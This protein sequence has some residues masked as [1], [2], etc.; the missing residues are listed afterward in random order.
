MTHARARQRRSLSSPGTRAVRLSP[1][2]LASLVVLGA[3]AGMAYAQDAQDPSQTVVVTGIRR[4]IETSVAIK[5]EST[6]VVEAVSAEDLGKLPDISIA[7]S[8]A[9]L[10]GLTAQRVN[11][12]DQV[13]SVRGMAP[14]FGVTLLNGR[15]VVSTGDNRSVEFD[16]FPSELINGA[17]VY[18][19]PDASLASQGLAGTVNMST[20]R[21]LD[22]RERIIS[23]G[24]RGER[25]SNGA[26]VPG[27]SATGNR[28]SVSYVDQFADNT[29]GL[30]LGFAHLDSTSQERYFKHWWWGNS[31]IWGG[32][33]RGL[34]NTDPAKAP[35][36]LQGFETGVTATKQVRDGALAVLEFK[37]NKDIRSQVDLYYSKFSQDA[38]GRELQADLG[39]NWSGDGTPGHEAN[40]G[41]IYS[42]IK[43]QLIGN[44][45][46]LVGGRV[47]NVDPRI[48]TRYGQRDDTITALGWNTEANLGNGLKGV[49]D[50]SWSKAKRDELVGEA[51]A[52]A[53][54]LGGFDF[55]AN[56]NG[57]FSQFTPLTNYGDPNNIQLRGLSGWG[58]LNG[59]GQAGSLSPINVNDELK[60][61]RLGVKKDLDWGAVN[62]FEGGVNYSQRSKDRN[63]TQTIYALKNG[64]TC[65][66]SDVCQPFP[67]GLLQSPVNLGFSN[68]P[69]LVSFDMMAAINAGLYNSGLVNQSSAPG[70]IWGVDE[71]VTTAYGKLDLD[72]N[73]GVPVR[74][75]L[76]L[77]VVHA[78][79]S[80]TGLA[81]DSNANAATAM[82]FGTS[83]TDV[84]PSLNLVAELQ[85]SLLMR[86]GM[87]K[88]VARPN[89]DDMRAGFSASVATSG[90]TIGKWSGSG[91]NPFLEPW[92]ARAIDISLEKYFGKRSYVSIAGFHKK[93]A[94]SIY[95]E[96]FQ[97]DF[98]GF[99]NT[100]G[101]T[102]VSNIGTLTAPIN[103]KGGHVAGHEITA[104]LEGNLLSPTLD[105][106]GVI[107]SYSHTVSNLPGTANDG[108]AALNRSLE[109]LSGEVYSLQGYYE[110]NGWQFRVAQRYRSKFVAEVRGVWIDK[111]LSAIDAERITDLQLGYSWESGPLKGVSVLLQVNNLD[112]TPYKTALADDSSTSTP[113]RM[114]P[115]RYIEYGRRYLLGVNYKF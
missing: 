105:G 3:P 86:F 20:V 107:A 100:S 60:S 51:Y 110:K 94:N 115:E 9:R 8:L 6:S 44:D 61:L 35:H 17:V 62:G 15:E 65:V 113:L 47:T 24:V 103:G 93:L 70:R 77:Q 28:I 41:P 58:N 56:P 43:T 98:T 68:V 45:R 63:S 71:K 67:A 18:K 54:T 83:Y 50:L 111:S 73:A 57:G 69:A 27:S 106:F 25:N 49:A 5:R 12:R 26:Q 16:Q 48:L 13:L 81:W 36:T 10:P 38:Q 102:P 66:G 59:V 23:V 114:M 76:G 101:T 96:D 33:F 104:A 30:A 72:F 84:L 91:G 42:N 90:Q 2:A 19:T 79:Q 1:L 55:V 22:F 34:E 88:V 74:G 21:P 37:P 82:S 99:P 52:S 75:N 31:A 7:E 97:F 4:A 92:R 95:V 11:G 53:T 109:G 39:P 29:V 46:Y 80:S 32:A 40:G 108:K 14:K 85:P 64:T 78:K 89:M 87:A 112:N